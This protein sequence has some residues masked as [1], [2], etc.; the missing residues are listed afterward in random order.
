MK[1]KRTG[2]P[3]HTFSVATAKNQFLAFRDRAA[4]TRSRLEHDLAASAPIDELIIDFHGVEAMTN[5]FADELIGKF[6]VAF[7][8]GDVAVSTVRLTGLNEETRDAIS[9]CLERRKL[10]AVDSDN[11]ALI[12]QAAAIEDTY[13]RAVQLGEFR[14]ADIADSM[15]ISLTNANNRLKRLVDAGALHRERVA[16]PEHGG[17][18]FTYRV[19]EYGPATSAR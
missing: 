11:G 4:E 13:S 7:A 3:T 16:S 12:G 14:A 9:V 15:Q 5:S 19:P 2:P 1:P 18:E 8:A 17:K 6:Y 10:A